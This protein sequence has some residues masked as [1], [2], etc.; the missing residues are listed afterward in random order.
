MR[1]APAAAY[2][3][4]DDITLC[5]IDADFGEQVPDNKFTFLNIIRVVEKCG[6]QFC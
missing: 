4:F 3:M 6:P 5:T 2:N 1:R